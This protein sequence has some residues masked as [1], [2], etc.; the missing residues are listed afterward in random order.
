MS[1]NKLIKRIPIV[2]SLA[3]FAFSIV[4]LP[5][6]QA[7]ANP[8]GGVSPSSLPPANE[9]KCA[10]KQEL[11]DRSKCLKE[12]IKSQKEICAK[13]RAKNETAKA[14]DCVKTVKAQTER[15]APITAALKA[16]RVEAQKAAQPKDYPQCLTRVATIDDTS[17]MRDNINKAIN[18]REATLTKLQK[19]VDSL[20]NEG[21]KSVMTTAL[22]TDKVALAIYKTASTK[23]DSPSALQ[24]IYCEA[25]FKLQINNFRTSQINML[26]NV[27]AQL[28]Y[29]QARSTLFN[30]PFNLSTYP[31]L[32]SNP[33]KAEVTTRLDASRQLTQANLVAI[34]TAYMQTAGAKVNASGEAAS[35][36]YTNDLATP[37]ATLAQAKTTRTTAMRNYDE[38]Q[39]IRTT[40]NNLNKDRTYKVAS[41]TLKNSRGEVVS[42]AGAVAL[43]DKSLEACKEKVDTSDAENSGNKKPDNSKQITAKEAAAKAKELK[44]C[45]TKL[46]KDSQPREATVVVKSGDKEY[47]KKLTRSDKVTVWRVER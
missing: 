30:D 32:A 43:K 45:R 35:L 46:K 4:V 6:N 13:Y 8:T 3:A 14:Q 11:A 17:D 20:K 22:S 21:A 29:D 44:E 41:V 5:M 39:V 10:D 1:L 37:K 40:G 24:N 42:P 34:A 26:K 36:T 9:G 7:A 19:R 2:V 16:K 47:T 12:Q 25:I 31:Q 18:K 28:K 33:L 27:D 23:T 38:A 15:L